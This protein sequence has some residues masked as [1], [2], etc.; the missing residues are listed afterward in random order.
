DI[1]ARV[2]EAWKQA[3][4]DLGIKFTSPFVVID[5]DGQRLEGLGLVHFFGRRL[6]AIISV[7]DGPLSRS[8][9][10]T[11]DDYFSSMLGRSYERYERQ[12]FIDTLDDW[13]FFGPESERPPWYSGKVW[14]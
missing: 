4:A 3:S 10:W 11:N 5:P 12:H 1:E 14:K 8:K 13:H 9:V 6:G 7:I 2:V